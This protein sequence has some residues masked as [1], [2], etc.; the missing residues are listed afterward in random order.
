MKYYGIQNE[1]KSYFNRLQK[2]NGIFV[3]IAII[4]IVNNEVENLKETTNRLITYSDIDTIYQ[5][6]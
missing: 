4:K 6:L 3:S 2:E 1:V 5:S